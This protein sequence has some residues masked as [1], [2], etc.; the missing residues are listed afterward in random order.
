MKWFVKG[1]YGM[2]QVL[3]LAG[4]GAG[5]AGCSKGGVNYTQDSSNGAVSAESSVTRTAPHGCQQTSGSCFSETFQTAGATGPV[6]ILFVVQTSS[7]IDDV[8]AGIVSG[9]NDFINT[10]P[11]NSD[12]NIGVMLSHGSTSNFSGVLY[13]AGTEPLVLKSSQ[14][15]DAQIETFL[16]QKL[17]NVQQDPD[18]GG[19]EEGMFSLF[20]G[21]TTSNLLSASQSAGMFR[22]NAAL[23]VVFIGD[24]RDICA[25]LPSGVPAETDPVKIAARLRDCEGLTAAGLTHQL[26]VLKGTEPIIVDGIIYARPPVPTGKEIGYGYI[27]MVNLNN[28]VA[29]DIAQDNIGN[30]LA[31]IGQLG[32]T[33]VSSQNTFTLSHSGIDPNKIIVTVNGVGATFTLS[34]DM[35]TITST[36][37]ANATVIIS[38][39]LKASSSDNDSDDD[40]HEYGDN[41]DHHHH[42][43]HRHH[44]KDCDDNDSYDNGDSDDSDDN[45]NSSYSDDSSSSYSYSYSHSGG[46]SHSNGNNYGNGHKSY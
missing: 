9:I 37:P 12:F 40:D 1:C 35:V 21:I 44:H 17:N 2:L 18:S 15:S 42:H 28:G 5:L 46:S 11:A 39:C 13:Q 26:Q 8:K 10:L 30:G 25:A 32:G 14:L 45:D 6:D 20:H 4:L 43:H 22:S 34:G 27:D 19:G 24:R 16:D 41:D 7:S 33:P 3:M 36:I 38:Y 31:N 23:G 29:I